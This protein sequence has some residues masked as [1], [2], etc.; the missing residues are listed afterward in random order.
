MLAIV[1]DHSLFR[2]TQSGDWRTIAT[3]ELHLSCVVAVGETIY[4]GT[5]D[6]RILRVSATGEMHELD[7]FN[8]VPGRDT[9][10]AGGTVID[11]QFVGPPLGIRSISAT[12]NGSV[13]LANVHIGGIPR[14]TDGGRTWQPT[15]D[16]GND[17]HQVLGHPTDSNIAIAAAATGLCVSRDGGATWT[18]ETEGLHGLHCTAVAFAGNDILVSAATQHFASEGAVYRRQ[19]DGHGPLEPVGDGL[20]RWTDR[21]VDTGCIGA[22]DSTL[23][24]ADGGGNLYVSTNAGVSWTRRATGLSAPSNVLVV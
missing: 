13:V 17:V 4:V 6:A 1:D 2:R 23:A 11:G 12:A 7:G 15:I 14:S 21:I 19:L 24:V 20:P 16:I 5:D 18:V 9:W 10:Y 3:S 8:A 22:R